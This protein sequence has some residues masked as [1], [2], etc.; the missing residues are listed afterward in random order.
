[1]A[2][3]D[4]SALAHDVFAMGRLP[5]NRI[6]GGDDDLLR[7]VVV[8][9]PNREGIAAIYPRDVSLEMRD[10]IK[11]G[12]FRNSKI[13]ARHETFIQSM[14]ASSNALRRHRHSRG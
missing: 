9:S 13:N 10:F 8:V 14:T 3:H 12:R 7:A 6:S 5:G 4:R 2:A 1:M 11:L